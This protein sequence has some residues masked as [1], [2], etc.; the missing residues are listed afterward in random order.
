MWYTYYKNKLSLSLGIWYAYMNLNLKCD[1]K[2]SYFGILYYL[3]ITISFSYFFFTAISLPLKHREPRNTFKEMD[4]VMIIILG[5][6]LPIT[7][8][9]FMYIEIEL[10]VLYI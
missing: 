8:D 4:V 3:N 1:F 7:K 9:A 5:N 10:Y 6:M 2:D